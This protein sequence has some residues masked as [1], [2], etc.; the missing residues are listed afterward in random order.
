MTQSSNVSLLPIEYCSL[1]RASQLLKCETSDL[2]HWGIIGAIDLG[3]NVRSLSGDLIL[4]GSKNKEINSIE[5]K[6]GMGGL[7]LNKYIGVYAKF[8]QEYSDDFENYNIDESTIGYSLKNKVYRVSACVSGLWKLPFSVVKNFEYLKTTQTSRLYPLEPSIEGEG[9]SNLFRLDKRLIV[10]IDKL[11][12]IKRDLML[13][14]QYI[15]GKKKIKSIFND[16]TLSV[17]AKS[18][19][20]D[21]KY[22]N[23]TTAK[24]SDMIKVL[25]ELN[26]GAYCKLAKSN[27]ELY[28]KLEQTFAS[29]GIKYSMPDIN[30]FNDWMGRGKI[31]LLKS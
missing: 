5:M 14:H 23:R 21:D 27:Q 20:Q 15:S 3:V 29:K 9:G 18:E 11:W 26:F 31:K 1:S 7:L 24:Q 16:D 6:G 13:L 12:I 8:I 30:T 10:S 2:I 19:E 28:N 25:M 17:K 22:K 4:D